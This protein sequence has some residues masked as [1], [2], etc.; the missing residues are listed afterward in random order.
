MRVGLAAIGAFM[1]RHRGNALSYHHSRF[2]AYVL[3]ETLKPALQVQP[4][5]QYQIGRLRFGNVLRRGLV[6]MDFR[7][8]FGNRFHHGVLGDILNYGESSYY[9]EFGIGRR[10]QA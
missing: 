8:R 7:A 3:E 5:P 1:N 2:V 9:F 10:G 6:I 4:V